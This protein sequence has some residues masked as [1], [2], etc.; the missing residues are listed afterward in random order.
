M[1]LRVDELF[2]AV[3]SHALATAYFDRVNKHEPKNAPGRGLTAAVWV[4][5]IEPALGKS[6]LMSTTVR[7]TLNVRVYSNMLQEPQDMID[8]EILKAIDAL[9]EAYSGDFELG[10]E[11]MFVDLLGD[12]GTALSAQ[13][14]YIS[15]DN[16]MYRVMTIVLPIIVDNLWDQEA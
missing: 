13:A 9:M 12:G 2:S 6:G 3:E 1:A 11:A 15:T 16:K 7:L 8:P 10:G 5:K 14:G 4:D